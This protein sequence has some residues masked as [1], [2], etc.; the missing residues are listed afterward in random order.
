MRIKINGKTEE[1]QQETVLQLLDARKIE[2][3]MVTVELNSQILQR[4][5]LA[6]AVLKEGDEL[7]FLFFMGGGSWALAVKM[8]LEDTV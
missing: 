3:R 4:E 2:P 1:I 6:L 5:E 8:A 7:E